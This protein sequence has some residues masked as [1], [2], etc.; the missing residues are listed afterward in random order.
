VAIDVKGCL[1]QRRKDAKEGIGFSA[2]SIPLHRRQDLARSR[3]GETDLRKAP[4]RPESFRTPTASYLRGF[5]FELRFK[6]AVRPWRLGVLSEA[7]VRQMP[8]AIDVKGCL[9]PRRQDAK[10]GMGL[11][12]KSIPLHRREDL[13][14]SREAAKKRLTFGRFP[15]LESF[16][17]GWVRSELQYP[18]FFAASRANPVPPD[19]NQCG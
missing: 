19:L 18:P 8:V 2:K 4:T 13:A 6:A 10:E 12:A 15:G 11:S 17:E 5:A 9:T 7:G 16:T 1:T 14:R 3:E